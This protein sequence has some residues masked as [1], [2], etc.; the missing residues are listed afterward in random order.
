VALLQFATLP[1]SIIS[2]A[3][4]IISNQQNQSTGN[5]SAFAVFNALLGCI[6]RLFTTS[7]EVKDP[8][9]FWGFAAAGLLNAVLAGQM[10]MYWKNDGPPSS[11]AHFKR[12]VTEDGLY[13]PVKTESEVSSTKRWSGRKL[14]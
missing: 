7:Q 5:L 6:A 1:L 3:P 11:A 12:R 10:L 8:L 14:D 9:I 2:K 4:Q 13:S